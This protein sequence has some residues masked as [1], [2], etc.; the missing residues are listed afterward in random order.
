MKYNEFPDLPYRAFRKNGTGLATY[1]G[2]KGDAPAAPDYTAAA[3]ATAQGNAEAARIAAQANRVNQYGPGGSIVYSQTQPDSFDQAGYDAANQQYQ[4]QLAAYNSK[5]PAVASGNGVFGSLGGLTGG[6]SGGGFFG[7]PPTAP[8]RN[9]FMRKGNPDQWSVTTNLSP[10]QQQIYDNKT[11]A[12]IG[13][14]N[15]ANTGIQKAGGLLSNPELDLSGVVGRQI[16]PGQTAQD[17]ILSRIQPQIDQSHQA[18]Q[19]Q[20]ANQGLTVGSEAYNNAMRTQGQQE[21][22]LRL[23]AATQGIGINQQARQQGI[24]EQAYLQ[25]RPLNLINA[26]RSGNQVNGPQFQNVPQQAT[27]SGPNYSAAADSLYGSQLGRYNA[28]VAQSN[29]TTGGLFNLGSAAIGAYG[30]SR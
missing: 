15:L 18:L 20:L 30:N 2:G 4:Q 28:G 5:P 3:Q 29:S 13:L 6:S 9:S 23:Q 10:A 26:L 11:Q 8:D 25:D 24:Q 27:T 21:N 1:E 17:A 22:D 14:G 7:G 16:N 19:T 12:D